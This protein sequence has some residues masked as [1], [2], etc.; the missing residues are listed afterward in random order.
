MWWFSLI[1]LAIA[2]LYRLIVNSCEI[3]YMIN[4]HNNPFFIRYLFCIHVLDIFNV[5]RLWTLLY[6]MPIM[7][8]L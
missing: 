1:V 3:N 4:Q 2:L 6:G 5:R 8:E 7:K